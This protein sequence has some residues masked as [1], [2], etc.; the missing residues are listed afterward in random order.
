MILMDYKKQLLK[1]GTRMCREQNVDPVNAV[2]ALDCL[3]STLTYNE[4]KIIY[5]EELGR[6]GVK[7]AREGAGW[8]EDLQRAFG[9]QAKERRRAFR[10]KFGR[11]NG[12][13]V[14]RP[15]L[16]FDTEDNSRGKFILGAAYG[17]FVSRSDGRLKHVEK[18]FY[19]KKEMADFLMIPR[20]GLTVAHN[21]E[22][23]I[24]NIEPYIRGKRLY[25][26]SRMVCFSVPYRVVRRA[27]GGKTKEYTERMLFYDTLNHLKLSLKEAGELVGLKKLPFNP[28]NPT[29]CLRDA[30]IT[31]RYAARL[32]NIY[33]SLGGNF[34]ATIASTAM[35]IFRRKYLDVQINPIDDVQNKLEREAYYGGRCENFVRG[36]RY[37]VWYIDVNSLYPSILFSEVF[38]HPNSINYNGDLETA[39]FGIIWATVKTPDVMY[40]ILPL[41]INNKLCF[42]IGTFKGV[43]CLNEF[44]YAMQNGYE[45]VKLHKFVEYDSGFSPFKEYIAEL[46]G[47]KVKSREKSI[48]Y[49]FYKTLMNALYGKF[50]ESNEIETYAGRLDDYSGSLD[51][52][53]L[54][55]SVN[56]V[57]YLVL[58]GAEIT[59]PIYSFP[60]IAAY[61]T[62]YGR[63]ALHKK[64]VETNAIYCDT[65]SVFTLER[66]KMGS[67]L[68]EWVL[69]AKY[70][71][72]KFLA[73]K[74][75]ETPTQLKLKGVPKSA[76]LTKNGK[77]SYK[78]PLR[79]R[80]ML[81]RKEKFLFNTWINVEKEVKIGK[82]D[83]RVFY[84]DGNSTPI[85]VNCEKA[86]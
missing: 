6:R 23:D 35:D 65:D 12:R 71:W 36:K 16:A 1:I 34:K 80:E 2:E 30:E 81:R 45:L 47:L 10:G 29:Y 11:L 56:G 60:V 24:N 86:G 25:S 49:I 44:R 28:E 59:Y 7:T 14:R 22:Y 75:Y 78:K 20:Y 21:L 9:Y 40:P 53:P 42:P 39:K 84:I 55:K 43:W 70:D 66:P 54:I 17:D 72:V 67:G 64:I 37:G 85:R 68:G 77:Y 18:V 27:V 69:K 62:A 83:K 73:P 50:G 8:V 74:N 48:E 13:V 19:D 4:N 46:H 58:K 31:Y 3:D 61:V 15:V 63:I 32:Q 57:D 33:N 76:K 41:R 5:F 52:C 82:N 79:F 51:G 26:K 38:P